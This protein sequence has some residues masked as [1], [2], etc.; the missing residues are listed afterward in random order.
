M[1]GGGANVMPGQV[2]LAHNGVLFL[3]EL[4]EFKR[5]VLES[6]RQPLED[7]CVTIARARGSL[8]FPASFT[9]IAATNPCPC[10]F[11]GDPGHACRCTPPMVQRYLSKL[12][13]P[14]LDRMD[15]QVEV[16]AVP[17][18]EL[19]DKGRGEPSREIRARVVAAR[20]RQWTRFEGTPVSA[21]P[22]WT[23]GWS[24]RSARSMQ[25]QRSSRSPP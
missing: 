5:D 12:S 13:G 25:R 3:D 14:L 21:T 10:G 19:R 6:L 23:S 8:S 17:P 7:R 4:T 11:R 2:S 22:R 18:G 9:L 1:I 24:K 20:E 15:I 16:P